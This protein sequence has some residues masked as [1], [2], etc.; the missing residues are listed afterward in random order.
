MAKEDW[1]LKLSQDAQKIL[2]ELLEKAKKHE[3]AYLQA[4]DVKVAQVWSALIEL[5]KEFEEI[6]KRV[7]VL[8]EPFKQI[9]E[10]GEVEKRKAIRKVVEELVKPTT[11]E[12]EEVVSKLVDALMKF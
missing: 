8:V 2:S 11:K 3:C 7:E 9:V 10:V 4:D 6:K 5:V 12:K 1:K